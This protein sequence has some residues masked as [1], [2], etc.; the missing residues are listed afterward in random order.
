MYDRQGNRACFR[1][2]L[3]Q[4]PISEWWLVWCI[5]M[6]R[7]HKEMLKRD[8]TCAQKNL[9]ILGSIVNIGPV[10]PSY[11]S[12]LVDFDFVI[13]NRLRLAPKLSGINPG[14]LGY[15]LRTHRNFNNVN[16]SST[17]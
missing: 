13:H 17:R 8:W 7:H 9:T 5:S 6:Y 3:N 4:T 1:Y 11:G 16:P 15:I 14:F 12:L 2:Y 10:W